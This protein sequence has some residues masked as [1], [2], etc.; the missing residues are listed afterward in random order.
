[1]GSSM[2]RLNP[3]HPSDVF[4]P[5][6]RTSKVTLACE[7]DDF[8]LK[9]DNG[10]ATVF[11]QEWIRH[12][13]YAGG[14]RVRAYAGDRGVANRVNLGAELWIG[15]RDSESLSVYAFGIS[16]DP[17]IVFKGITISRITNFL[18]SPAVELRTDKRPLLNNGIKAVRTP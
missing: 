16:N 3:A 17:I 7:F 10:H 9:D 11:V 4:E 8:D 13:N 1:M 12:A 5:G 15:I 14:R 2:V 18:V 6:F